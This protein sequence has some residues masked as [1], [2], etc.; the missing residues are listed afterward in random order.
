MIEELGI[1]SRSYVT[2]LCMLLLLL[3]H[4]INFGFHEEAAK[5][6]DESTARDSSGS[7]LY[8]ISSKYVGRPLSRVRH[9][10]DKIVIDNMLR[11][12][13]LLK[14]APPPSPKP[15]TTSYKAGKLKKSEVIDVK[16]VRIPSSFIYKMLVV[17]DCFVCYF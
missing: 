15:P 17:V 3:I 12:I 6:P 11:R 4:E 5:P 10:G 7:T 1:E 9:F 2:I 8:I 16:S 14:V 13:H